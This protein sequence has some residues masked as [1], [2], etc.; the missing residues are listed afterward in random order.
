MKRII[1]I[2]ILLTV[3]AG[4]GSGSGNVT[5]PGFSQFR[6]SIEQDGLVRDISE[7]IVYL[8]KK[9]FTIIIQMTGSAGIFVNAS[10]SPESVKSAASAVQLDGIEGFRETEVQ[11]G[12][13]NSEEILALSRRAPN[14]WNY[15]ND[16]EHRFSQVIK[17]PGAIICRRRISWIQNL[18]AD[19]EKI[20]VSRL[21]EDSLYLVFMRLEWN[22][23]YSSRVERKREYM[24]II[25]VAPGT[26][27]PNNVNLP[28]SFIIQG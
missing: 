20:P 3:S 9:P 23:D 22:T 1:S 6:L 14:Y 27:K 16:S 15:V 13:F 2:I 21:R 19:R 17:R 18:D 12:L 25:F 4:C 7:H 26:V 5:D 10:L 11:E 28:D 24:R 8:E